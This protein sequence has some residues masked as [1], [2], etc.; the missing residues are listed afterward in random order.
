MRPPSAPGAGPPSPSPSPLGSSPGLDEPTSEVRDLPLPAPPTPAELDDL[1]ARHAILVTALAQQARAAGKDSAGAKRAATHAAQYASIEW[2]ALPAEFLT[3]RNT[4][5]Y[6]WSRPNPR[7]AQ[8]G[9]Y[10]PILQASAPG[11][12]AFVIDT[13]GSVPAAALDAVTAE[14]GAYLAEYSAT[15]LDVLYADARVKGRS[16][17]PPRISPFGWS[18]SAAAVPRS[19]PLSRTWGKMRSRPLVSFT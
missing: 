11:R 1:L 12:I 7:Y 16:L 17:S 10:L 13:S 6:S 4:Q 9:F 5:D 14:L 19:G 8:L 3:S 18:R 2:R 15:T